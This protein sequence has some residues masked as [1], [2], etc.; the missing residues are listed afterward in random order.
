MTKR[1]ERLQWFK[2]HVGKRVYRNANGCPCPSCASVVA[3]G[4][5]I[6]D[7]LHAEYLC[8]SECD[9]NIE[10]TPLR[11]G[12]TKEEVEEWLKTNTQT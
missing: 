2:D 9:L 6:K 4:L 12:D 5:V 10:G 1:S 8:D 11:Y 3:H 7:S